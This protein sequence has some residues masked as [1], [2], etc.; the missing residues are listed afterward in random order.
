MKLAIALI[1]T[2]IAIDTS[3]RRHVTSPYKDNPALLVAAPPGAPARL[4]A[5]QPGVGPAP[6]DPASPWPGGQA[7]TPQKHRPPTARRL[8]A[9]LGSGGEAPHS[10]GVAMHGSPRPGKAALAVLAVLATAPLAAAQNLEVHYI[11]VGWGSAVFLKGPDGTTVLLEA[12]NTGDGT[13]EVVPYL[14]SIGHAPAAGFPYTIPGH[15]HCD[16]IGGLDEVIGAGYDVRVRNYYNG[17][18]YASSCVDQW[19]AAAGGT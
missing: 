8:A 16:H 4:A 3:R 6:R 19:N 10:K 11:N 2:A 1:T 17:S 9:H 18:T 14:Q 15:Q 7:P 12:G 5:R 13:N